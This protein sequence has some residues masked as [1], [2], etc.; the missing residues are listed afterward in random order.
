M[1]GKI[2]VDCKPLCSILVSRVM[3]GYWLNNKWQHLL[4]THYAPGMVL[5]AVCVLS[6][7]QG[8]LRHWHCFWETAA[9]QELHFPA[10]LTS[11]GGHM[12][13]SYQ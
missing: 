8:E 11:S 10:C 2:N 1:E 3:Q 12:T 5:S 6:S 4:S 13:S 9:S 7:L